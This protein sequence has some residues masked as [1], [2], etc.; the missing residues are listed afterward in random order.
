MSL[1]LLT[2]SD[3][4]SLRQRKS[5]GHGLSRG[6]AS[7]S[8]CATPSKRYLIL[9]YLA[10]FDR[11]HYPLALP[12]IGK[13]DPILLQEIIRKLKRELEIYKQKVRKERR[14]E[15]GRK[16]KELGGRNQKG[17]LRGYY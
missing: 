12:Y 11:I 2:Y 9:T 14:K 5:K 8:S 10:E 16:E 17:I 3:L 15:G 13:S 7:D 6:G 1:E 4:E